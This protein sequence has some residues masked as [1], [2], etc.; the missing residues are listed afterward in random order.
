[1]GLIIYNMKTDEGVLKL[2]DL[3]GK[4][5]NIE[6]S[7]LTFRVIVRDVRRVYGRLQYKITPHTGRGEAWKDDK[8]VKLNNK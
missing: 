5:G 4:E 2:K 8:S 6:V 7:G 1:M 3:I